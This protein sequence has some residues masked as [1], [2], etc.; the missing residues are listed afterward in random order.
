MVEETNTGRVNTLPRIPQYTEFNDVLDD[1]V[2]A[3]VV[4]RSASPA[5]ALA[6]AADRTRRLLSD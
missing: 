5:E 1:A 4:E 3:A 2:E 6:E